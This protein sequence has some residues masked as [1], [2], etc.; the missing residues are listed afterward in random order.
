MAATDAR[1]VP[2]KNIAY[3]VSFPILDADGDLVTG[4][5]A[6]DSEVSI[7]GAAFA[8]ATSEATEIATASGVYFLDLTAAEMN[9]DTIAVIVKTST[10]GAKTTTI[11]MYPEEVGDYRADVV[12]WNGSAVA[13]PT[14]AGVPEVDVTHWIGTAAATPTVAGVPEVDVTHFNGTAGTF[15]AGRPEVNTSHVGGTLQ[16]AG[17]IIGDTNDIQARLPAALVGGRI[18]ASVGAV[19]ANAITAA[20]IAT[21]AI[22]ADALAADAGTEIAAAVWNEDA[23]AHQTLGTFGQAIGDPVADATTIYQSVVTDAAGVNVAADI[24]AVKADTAAILVDTGTTLDG[25]IPAALVGGRMDASVGAVAA[26]AITAA[27][28]ADG[29]ID[30]AT[31]AAG[32][33][34]A[35]AI[36][37]NAI[38][39]SELA[40][41]AANEIAD[42]ILARQMTEAY[43]ADGVA[44]TVGEMQFMLWAALAEF[45]ISSTTI[46][47]KKLDGTTAAMTFTLDNAI[48]PTSRTRAT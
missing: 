26:N 40:A 20:A 3:R 19:A 14:V 31:F 41:D 37:A 36:A 33:I 25:R 47:A 27:G 23:T 21:G 29:A 13:T 10:A 18:D 12:R 11:V 5:A 24:V 48:N 39:A 1:P 30:A 6:L 45:A 32:A 34:D 7:D 35:A 44:P 9:G 4:A 22:D 38:G 17:D 2:R 43:A 15:A 8:D 46:T 16:T 28:I 42:A